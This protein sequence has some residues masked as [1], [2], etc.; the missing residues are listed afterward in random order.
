MYGAELWEGNYETVEKYPNIV[1]AKD[2]FRRSN[3]SLLRL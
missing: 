1:I 3:L 2:G